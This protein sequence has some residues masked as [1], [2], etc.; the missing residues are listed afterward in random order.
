MQEALTRLERLEEDLA[1]LQEGPE[2]V[3]LLDDV[4]ALRETLEALQGVEYEQRHRL[5][6]DLRTPLNAIA[7]WAH[8][9]QLDAETPST[10]ARAA[11]VLRR[12]VQ[13]LA[14]AIDHHTDGGHTD[15][16]HTDGGR[17]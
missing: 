14:R 10:V 3:P 17:A 6:H 2:R 13:A 9:L 16:G 7:G 4:A 11:D 12:N 1:R 5:G 15:G 8:I